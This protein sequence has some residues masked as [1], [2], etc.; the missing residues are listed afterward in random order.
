MLLRKR[1][2]IR[3]TVLRARPLEEKIDAMQRFARHVV[4]WFERGAL[5]AVVDKT[6]PLDR[7]SEAHAYM[8][9]NEGFGKV[10]LTA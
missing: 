10:V 5:R 8:A 2:T 9:S 6:F 4:P 7:A 1:L 3:G